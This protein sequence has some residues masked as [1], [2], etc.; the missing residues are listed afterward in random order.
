M[1]G[2]RINLI[3]QGRLISWPG[4]TGRPPAQGNMFRMDKPVAEFLSF[5]P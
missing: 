5:F 1:Q 3:F 4:A 2:Y